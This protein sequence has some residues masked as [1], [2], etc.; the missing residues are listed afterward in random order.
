[1]ESWPTLSPDMQNLNG[2]LSLGMLAGEWN[3]NR[4]CGGVQ[5]E[6]LLEYHYAEENTKVTGEYGCMWGDLNEPF[7]ASPAHTFGGI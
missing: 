4:L 7:M 3:C 2:M 1:M 6:R 5:L